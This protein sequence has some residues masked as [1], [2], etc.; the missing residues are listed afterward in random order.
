MKRY[1][2][3]LALTSLMIW[4]ERAHTEQTCAENTSSDACES[5]EC[6]ASH[7]C[8]DESLNRNQFYI[9]PEWYHLTRT[10]TG[11]TKL[12]GD[13]IGV[14]IGYDR[15]KRFGWYF[16]VEGAYSSGTLK[17]KSGLKN[18][19][20]S[21]FTDANI[22][23]RFGYTLQQKEGFQASFTPFIGLG[24]D[25]EKNNFKDPSPIHLH[26]KTKFPY[27]TAGFLSW[28]H[29]AP[30][31]EL[32][33]NFK[34]KAPYDT[35]CHVSHDPKGEPVTQKVADRLHYRLDL[36]ITYR[37]GCSEHMALSLVPFFDAR[38][39]GGHPNYPYNYIKTTLRSW[40]LNF[41]LVYR[42]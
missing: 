30:Q 37:I 28:A 39:F 17:G 6:R 32:G 22:E 21:H 20:K 15:L 24:Y 10:K 12:H 36:P 40:G 13:P 26:F 31:W 5:N 38:L 42:M 2:L 4:G 34:V 23:G 35:S 41:Q 18:S 1:K 29:I 3:L 16:G 27:G 14:R 25:V 8:Y 7:K 11:G 9:A 33:L 19:L